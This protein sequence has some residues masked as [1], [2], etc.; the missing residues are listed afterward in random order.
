[1]LF[2]KETS[3]EK[4]CPKLGPVIFQVEVLVLLSSQWTSYRSVP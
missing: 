4:L 2:V 1:M 3:S